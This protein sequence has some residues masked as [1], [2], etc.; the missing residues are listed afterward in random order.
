[1]ILFESIYPK[2][3]SA[4]PKQAKKPAAHEDKYYSTEFQYEAP[5]IHQYE[6][7]YGRDPWYEEEPVREAR[8]S[9]VEEYIP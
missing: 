1:M 6:E 4:K 9:Y 3:A 5:R 7:A 2:P 8:E